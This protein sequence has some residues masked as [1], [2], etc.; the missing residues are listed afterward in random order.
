MEQACR[1]CGSPSLKPCKHSAPIMPQNI[2]TYH[3]VSR[4]GFSEKRGL[5]LELTAKAR[6]GLHQDSIQQ[7]TGANDR[8][9]LGAAGGSGSDDHQPY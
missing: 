6:G 1:T 5:P 9:S 3:P 2:L 4:A 7:L 8:H